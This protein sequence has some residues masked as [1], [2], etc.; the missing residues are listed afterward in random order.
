[1]DRG[2]FN[3]AYTCNRV[4]TDNMAILLVMV[5]FGQWGRFGEEIIKQLSCKTKRTFPPAPHPFYNSL[6]DLARI[7]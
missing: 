1:M 7:L 5:W 6:I 2:F 4:R 3:L